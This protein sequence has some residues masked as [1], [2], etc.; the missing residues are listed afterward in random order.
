[1]AV[2]K[3]K[4]SRANTRARRSQW[5]ASVPQLVKTVEN[6]RVTYSLPHQAKLVTDSAGNALFYEYK[7]RKVADA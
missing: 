3:R 1:M 7:G 2:P 6:G 4:M 5:K